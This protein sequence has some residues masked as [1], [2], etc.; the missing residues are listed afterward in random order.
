MSA[1]DQDPLSVLVVLNVSGGVEGPMASDES[2]L[3]FLWPWSVVS[4][5]WTP[6]ANSTPTE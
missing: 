6:I 5:A 2:G 1:V 3:K 4:T